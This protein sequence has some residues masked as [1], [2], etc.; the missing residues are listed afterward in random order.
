LR[1]EERFDG[2]L[3]ARWHITE[4]GAANVQQDTGALTLRVMPSNGY[5]NAQM[6][7]YHTAAGMRFRWQPPLRMTV[8]ARFEG[9]IRG[10]AGFGFWNHPFAPNE[11]GVRL[12]QSIWYF[13]ASPPSNMALAQGVAGCGWKAATLDAKRWQFLAL[14]PAA[15]LGVLL[16]RIP[17]LYSRLWSI[18]Q[19]AIGVSEQLLD[20][21]L[22]QAAH[23]YTL[24]W[25]GDS[26]AFAVDDILVH[27]APFSPHG[28]LGFAAWIDNQ[29]AIVTPQGQFGFG[30]SQIE[31]EQRLVLEMIHI[32]TA[33]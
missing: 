1:V 13:F 12:P 25:R 18:G 17:A 14:L 6:D 26:A 11:R 23:T 29:Y 33:A 4:T 3:S 31:D 9:D 10:T 15:P 27:H 22:M 21:R 24:E 16:M 32:E 8:R 30:I 5:S 28:T 19:R 20:A 2:N 7:D